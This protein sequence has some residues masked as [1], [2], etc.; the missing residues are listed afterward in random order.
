[1]LRPHTSMIR[2][3]VVFALD[4]VLIGGKDA[5]FLGRPA[6]VSLVGFAP[7]AI[8]PLAIATVIWPGLGL[9]GSWA[10]QLMSMTLR[11]TANRRRFTSR[12]WGAE[13][14]PATTG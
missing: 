14:K 2:G 8:A 10:A 6:V 9:A 11:A 13:P 1:M 7:L 5:R 4:G 3:A 12:R